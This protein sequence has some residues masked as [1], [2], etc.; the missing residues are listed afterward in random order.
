MEF[1]ILFLL[2]LSSKLLIFAKI[3]LFYIDTI[4]STIQNKAA[5]TKYD[6]QKIFYSISTKSNGMAKISSSQINLKNESTFF[7][8]FNGNFWKHKF[9][10]N[11]ISFYFIFLLLTK[12]YLKRNKSQEHHLKLVLLWLTKF[13]LLKSIYKFKVHFHSINMIF[14]SYIIARLYFIIK[15]KNHN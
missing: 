9:D 5:R 7:K 14:Y 6:E 15:S 2:N 8:I 1:I 3:Y 4:Q 10:M 12:K 13:Y 11:D